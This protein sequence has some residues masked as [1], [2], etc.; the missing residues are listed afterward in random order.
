MQARLQIHLDPSRHKA[1]RLLAAAADTSVPDL[2]RRAIDH[3]LRDE[4][5]RTDWDNELHV[6]MHR[7]HDDASD[8]PPP[9]KPTKRRRTPTSA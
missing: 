7:L 5:A 9:A 1:L 8:A 2:V 4:F 3:L 6:L